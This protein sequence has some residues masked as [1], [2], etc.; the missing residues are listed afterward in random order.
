LSYPDS[1]RLMFVSRGYPGYPQG[2]GN[3]TY[4]AYRDIQQLNT[5]F[6]QFAAFQSF[7][8]LALTD[9]S[10][11]VRVNINY[12]TP[13]YF[14]LLGAQ[15]T[16]GRTLRPQEDRWADGDPVVVLSHGFWQRE[17]ASD[18][19]IV[20]RVIHLNQQAFTVIG[21]TSDSFR[22]APGAM[23]TGEAVDAWLPLGLSNR[24]TG[25]S[26]PTDRNSAILWGIGHLKPTVSV[27][28][29]RADFAAV[30]K[31][32]EKMYPN[33]DAGFTMVASPLRDQLTGQ[34]YRPVRLLIGASAFILLI[35][36]ANV[37]NLLLARLVAR[38]RELAVRSALGASTRRLTRQML[39]E[40]L[41][42]VAMASALGLA[43]AYSG[44]RGLQSWGHANLPSVLEFRT[45]GWVLAGSMLASMVTFLLLGLGPALVATRTNLRDALNQGARQAV[46]LEHRHAG[47]ALVI[48]EVSLALV[49]LIGAGLLVASFRRM[50]GTDL[51]FNT[52]SLLTLRCDLTSDKYATPEARAQFTKTL[53][54]KL[55]S[56]PGVNSATVWG[57]G[58]PGRAT[59]VIEAIPEGRQPDDPRSIVMSGRHS[60][61][62]GALSN[63]GIPLLRGRDFTW[64]DTS[65][66]PRVAIISESTAR[67]SWPG[68]DPIGKRF[69]PIGR[70]NDPITVIGIASDVRLRQRLDLSDAAIGISP[71]GLGPQLDVYLPY[72]QRPNKAVVV[73]TRFRGDPAI[74]VK[75]TRSAVLGLDPTLPLYDIRLLEDRLAAQDN[76]SLALTLVTVSYA[77]LALFLAALGLFSVLA[78]T[79]SR[80]TRELGIRLALGATQRDLLMMV[81]REGML[82]TTS[83]IL[84]GLVA[85]ALLTRAMS[86]LLFGV[87]P[88][89]PIV[90]LSLSLFLLGVAVVACYLPARRTMKVDLIIAL[91]SE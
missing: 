88:T 7:G 11:P 21:V 37:A 64:Q 38:R 13:S 56:L 49:L 36:C 10:E 16:L 34:F 71:G 75:E 1:S 83:G 14:D 29:A 8:A 65:T 20:G 15:T 47:K 41:V 87:R 80:R 58:M 50:T 51:G 17:F 33:S 48:G 86:S 30:G 22:D 68:Q 28:Q 73:L 76:S 54:E 85:A 89:D 78:H 62:P 6:D 84:G 9:G 26:N 24:L 19:N 42:L 66:S 72:A 12:V 61:N 52:R 3:F 70:A 4:P 69:R 39:V 90:Y 81:L 63:I 55:G 46:S 74:V 43:I 40:N 25:Y 82:L 45:G 31:R 35:G 18:A 2:G 27:E 32:L 91:R 60:V 77:V 5:S 44:L 79:V 59:W 23:D 57:P 67:I 53:V